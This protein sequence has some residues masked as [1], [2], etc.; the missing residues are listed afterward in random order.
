MLNYLQ[1]EDRE[2][3]ECILFHDSI[4]RVLFRKT[5][6]KRGDER[7]FNKNVKYFL[8]QQ[9]KIPAGVCIFLSL[10][11]KIV[12][13]DIA[14]LPQFRGKSAYKAAASLRDYFLAQNDCVSLK[15]KIYKDNKRSL[16]FALALGFQ[17]IG[18]NKD[19]LIL[20]VTNNG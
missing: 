3:I 17:I 1:I 14:I 13:V 19:Q 9:D 2:A 11:D 8:F 7:L 15:A 5:S 16:Y 10:P 12:E 4:Y 18:K 20:E 6:P